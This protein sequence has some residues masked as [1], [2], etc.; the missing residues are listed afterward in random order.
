[1]TAAIVA[2]VLA[3]GVEWTNIKAKPAPSNGDESGIENAPTGEGRPTAVRE[4]SN[5]RD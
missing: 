4:S 5:S 3:F 2:F 1:M